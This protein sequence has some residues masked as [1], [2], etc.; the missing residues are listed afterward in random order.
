[1]DKDG[2]I[3]GLLKTELLAAGIDNVEIREADI[4]RVDLDAIPVKPA[5][6]WWC[7]ATCPTIFHPRSSFN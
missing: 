6:R 7:W 3:I 1:V 5:G 2:R 4:L